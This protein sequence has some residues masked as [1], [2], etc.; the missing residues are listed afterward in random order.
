MNQF[1]IECPSCHA[2]L[3]VGEDLLGQQVACPKCGN[4][5]QLPSLARETQ[6]RTSSQPPPVQ[7]VS[8]SIQNPPQPQSEKGKV[9][10]ILS[11]V[12]G[13]LTLMLSVVPCVGG[14][15]AVFGLAPLVLGIIG[16]IQSRKKGMAI[17]G[18]VLGGVSILFGLANPEATRQELEKTSKQIEQ[19]MQEKLFPVKP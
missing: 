16:T 6:E 12:F 10:S 5:I 14:M 2:V 4:S 1:E 19:Q 11:L 7:V 8:L 18:I 13:I 15:S 9:C 17:A 3:D